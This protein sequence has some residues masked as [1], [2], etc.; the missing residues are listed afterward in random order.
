MKRR[1]HTVSVCLALAASC[2]AWTGAASLYDG[3]VKPS[4][5]FGPQTWWHWMNGNVSKEGIVADLDALAAIGVSGVHIFDAGCDIPA[6]PLK[7]NSPEW[8][9]TVK[10][11]VEEAQ[12]RRMK[13]ILPNCSGYSVA[14]GPWIAADNAMKTVSYT[15]RDV[16]GPAKLD[17]ALDAPWDPVGF[18]ED[19]A[20]LAY[21]VPAAELPTME[22]AGVK[23]ASRTDDKTCEWTFDFDSPYAA[24]DLSFR[25]L[26]RGWTTRC[27]LSVETADATGAW[28]E[29]L[30]REI[31]AIHDGQAIR[32][33]R[34]FA[35]AE[36]AAAKWRV[37]FAFAGGAK[38]FPVS[39]VRLS[40]AGRV[41]NISEWAWFA[42]D[43]IELSPVRARADQVVP[44]ASVRNLTARTDKSGRLRWDVPAG[45]WR[46]VR[47]G[48]AAN[49][50]CCHPASECG[51]GFECDKLSKR[52]IGVH[53]DAY[54]GRLCDVLGPKLCGKVRYG[55]TG[56]L[57]DSW[58]AGTQNWTQGFEREFR[59]RKG[60]DLVPYLPILTG[61]VVDGAEATERVLK[62]YRDVISQMFAENFSDEFARK[63]HER[64]LEF[65]TEAYGTF[66]S[67]E[68]L[69]GRSADVDMTEFWVRLLKVAPSTERLVPL[70]ARRAHRKN[71]RGIVASESFTGWPT[72]A[73]W[74]QDPFSLKAR[75]DVKYAQGVNRVVYH[76]YAHQPWTNPTYWPG[77]TMGQWGIH[78]ERTETWWYEAKDWITYQ[79]RCQYLL[80][81]G[82]FV[83]E[84]GG[85]GLWWTH[86]RLDDGTDVFFVA[87]G[88]EEAKELEVA[89]PC[90]GRSPELWDAENGARCRP[91]EWRAA[92]GVT[93]VRL[94]F[95][96][97]GSAFVVFPA[98]AT[99]ALPCEKA[100]REIS[101]QAVG[102]PWNVS[103]EAPYPAPAPI[104]LD[105]LRSLAEHA[106]PDVRH[107]SGKAIY[108]RAF[109]FDRAAA[110]DGARVLLDLGV[111]KNL[112]TVVVNGREFPVC[113]RPPFRVDV[114]DALK[115]GRNELEV[116]VTNLWVN[117]LIGDE[118]KAP[119]VKWN[120]PRLAEIPA[121]VKE[122][123]ASPTGRNTFTTWR[124]W[125][126]GDPLLPSG[127]L[128]PV[129][130]VVENLVK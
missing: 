125:R 73:R 80:Q 102:G 32:N 51:V 81:Q 14:G 23:I 127:L 10:F 6:G 124:H 60:Y 9:E 20:V 103:F 53:F 21:P 61:A 113:W 1:F 66:P 88:V 99:D 31:Y 83:D 76:R 2:C 33:L 63:C 50:K 41:G 72:E 114:T 115:S 67:T 49:G 100:Y 48:Y 98:V 85:D 35:F 46:I 38:A 26:G 47:M 3:F 112:A 17:V 97:A 24:S 28:R 117:R 68:E 118:E 101:R 29:V 25:M 37:R 129:E 16:T 96:P 123:K 44:L 77:M 87:T 22:A 19:I 69:Y 15:V 119:D 93:T 36:T 89:L 126:K 121:W 5:D 55:F 11:A 71:P 57:I 122:G 39:D 94:R 27:T 34:D 30:R 65:W 8:F 40:R 91:R 130:L 82:A 58:E 90:A 52:G 75:G 12:K 4:T 107:F 7:F 92:G 105:A 106:E 56:V 62:D 84:K 108:R 45:T 42:R 111:V 18:Y 43:D 79:T 95:P 109:D 74:T 54:V 120:G 70:V 86:R 110:A 78:F 13:V 116:R 104:V 59:A 64:G 128:G